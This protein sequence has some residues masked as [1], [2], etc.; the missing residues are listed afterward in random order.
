MRMLGAL[1][2]LEIAQ[3]LALQ[4]AAPQHALHGEL[5][6]ALR[7]AAFE[8][9][10]RRR[11]LH[12]ARMARM[13]VIDLVIVLL[14]GEDGL[15][16]IDDDDVVAAIDMRRIEGSVLALEA[17]CDKGSQAADDETLGVDHDPLL[18]ELARFGD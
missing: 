16:G 12:A 13:A 3:E 7:E 11:S 9:A 4:R 15:L 18:F 8:D 1:V 14:A 17:Q 6:D 10:L 2:D 5:D